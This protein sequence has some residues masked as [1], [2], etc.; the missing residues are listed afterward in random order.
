[1][2]EIPAIAMALGDLKG[3]LDFISVG[4]NDLS[5]YLFSADR[6]NAGFGNLLSPWQPALVRMLQKIAIDS[7]AA[8]ITSAVCGESASDPAFAVVLAGLGFR[9][10]SASRSQVGAVRSALSS[11]NLEQAQEVAAAALSATTADQC[12]AAVLGVLAKLA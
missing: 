3:K 7:E 10:V 9:S 4:T 8:G 6:M 2:V 1:M 12:K 11:V 5:Q